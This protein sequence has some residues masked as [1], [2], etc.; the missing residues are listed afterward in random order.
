MN[1]PAR[2]IS[3]D[4]SKLAV[5]PYLV[6]Y[7]QAAKQNPW[8]LVKGELSWF[9]DDGVNL[10]YN[11]VDR[12][13]GTAIEGK[14]AFFWEGDNGATAHFTFGE[15]SRLSNQYANYLTSL[16]VVKGDRVFLFL[17]RIPV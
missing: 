16:G 13:V 5:Q 2:R 10:A 7:A 6:D 11:A 1:D 15:L 4:L 3:K 8:E 17:P 12:H 14:T 9:G